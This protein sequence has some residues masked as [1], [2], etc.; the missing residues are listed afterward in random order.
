MAWAFYFVSASIQAPNTKKCPF[1]RRIYIWTLVMRRQE[2]ALNPCPKYP[3]D[4]NLR[5]FCAE[6]HRDTL[7]GLEIAVRK[8]NLLTVCFCKEQPKR[9]A[10]LW[11]V[12]GLSAL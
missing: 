6:T 4:A 7:N 12:G 5:N 10:S 2:T 11:G 8:N 3:E 9:G 1:Y